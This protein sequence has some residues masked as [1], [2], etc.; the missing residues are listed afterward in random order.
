MNYSDYKVLIETVQGRLC[1]GQDEFLFNLAS[2]FVNSNILEIGSW[3]GRSS[4]SIGFACKNNN[5][6]VYCV[7]RW[8]G[9][10]LDVDYELGDFFHIW[11]NNI[12]RL[13]LGDVV[14]PIKGTSNIVLP[15]LISENKK[16]NMVFIDASHSYVNVL[17]DFILSYHLL[18]YG[19]LLAMHDVNVE[20]WHDVGKV[21]NDIAIHMLSDIT[22]CG[23]LYVGRKLELKLNDDSFL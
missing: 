15:K 9:H 4:A 5:S 12:Y 18:N 20:P 21:W 17:R 7:D 16:F 8:E 10:G 13:G 6:K 3:H 23:S 19:G 11:Q 2:N 14:F 22:N 1:H